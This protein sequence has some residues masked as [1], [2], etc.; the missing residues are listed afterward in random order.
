MEPSLPAPPS[1]PRRLVYLGTPDA[2]VPPLRALVDAGFEVALVVT[3]P[4][5]R[6]G[7]RG[8]PT[9]SPVKAAA[10]ELGLP[11]S[12][13]VDDALGVGA[14]LGVVVA[15][16]QLL[17]RH[18]LEALPM[19]NVHFSLLPRWRGAAPVERAILAGDERTGVAVMGVTE[20]LDEGPVYAVEELVIGADETADSLR[21]RLVDRGADLLVRTLT[22]GL[23]DPR[24]QEGEVTYAHKVGPDD[25]ELDW[26]LPAASLERRVRV[27]GAWTTWRGDRCKVWAARVTDVPSGA[28]AAVPGTV[29][30][31]VV[32]TGDGGLALVEVQPAGRA[33]MDAGDW[34]RGARPASGE[35]LG[36]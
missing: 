27:G 11:V 15:F 7:R 12:T 6:R 21:S 14:D 29:R 28:E 34:W 32:V 13:E 1:T 16:G 30:D 2:A 35:R 10:A 5:R 22:A 23:A 31:G 33:R 9:P 18:V 8:A 3:R 4:D 25:L 17:R 20:A 24:P 26:S 36:S 19:V